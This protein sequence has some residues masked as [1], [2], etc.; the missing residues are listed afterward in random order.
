MSVFVDEAVWPWRGKL[1]CHMSADSMEE[2]HEFANRL[3]LKRSWFQDAGGIP[4]YDLTESKRRQALAMGA[5]H[6]DDVREFTDRVRIAIGRKPM[7]RE[8]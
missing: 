3:G 1:W 2:L 7:F 4:H 5:V 8:P 6:L